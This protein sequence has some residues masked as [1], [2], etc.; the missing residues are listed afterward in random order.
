MKETKVSIPLKKNKYH[1]PLKEI[2]VEKKVILEKHSS[3]K[4]KVYV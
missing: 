3:P 2:I 1:F 4:E